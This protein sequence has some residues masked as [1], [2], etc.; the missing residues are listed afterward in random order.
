M[1]NEKNFLYK[2][3]NEAMII[4]SILFPVGGIFLVIMTIWAVG[5][6]APSEIPLFVSVFSLFF[7]V[8]PLLLHIYRKKVWLK[9]YMQNY[10]NSEG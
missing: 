4:F 8:P 10:K 5:A 2:K 3:I 6:K 9:K 7:F 1:K